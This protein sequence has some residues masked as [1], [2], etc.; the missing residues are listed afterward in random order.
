M[1][2]F[3]RKLI[4]GPRAIVENLTRNLNIS[5]SWACAKKDYHG[6]WFA[7][8]N[9]NLSYEDFRSVEEGLDGEQKLKFHPQIYI[10]AMLFPYILT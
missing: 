10:S 9:I 4:Y 1:E 2:S 5:R 8:L 7:A 6:N 3:E